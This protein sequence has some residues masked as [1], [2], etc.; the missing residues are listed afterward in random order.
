MLSTEN[1]AFATRAVLTAVLYLL[2]YVFTAE[3]TAY[4]AG[5]VYEQNLTSENSSEV[6][7]FGWILFVLML[8][9]PVISIYVY[10]FRYDS[11][12]RYQLTAEWDLEEEGMFSIRPNC[13]TR[14]AF[15]WIPWILGAG[16]FFIFMSAIYVHDAGDG[17]LSGGAVFFIFAPAYIIAGSAISMWLLIKTSFVRIYEDGDITYHHHM[18]IGHKEFSVDEIDY[19][20]DGFFGRYVLYL[21][22]GKKLS[23]FWLMSPSEFRDYLIEQG[24]PTKDKG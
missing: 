9:M 10:K 22:S 14:K 21:K 23:L 3:G 19:I 7:L 20:K 6:T 1:K 4:A 8:V 16:F 15:R 18:M 17:P 11:Q 12:M 2:F 5:S 24:I 13:V